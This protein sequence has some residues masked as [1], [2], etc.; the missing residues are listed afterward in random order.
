[1]L[2]ITRIVGFRYRFSSSYN[3]LKEAIADL[4]DDLDEASEEG[5]T[6]RHNSNLDQLLAKVSSNNTGEGYCN[7]PIAANVYGGIH[8][9]VDNTHPDLESDYEPMFSHQDIKDLLEFTE[10]YSNPTNPPSNSLFVHMLVSY[11]GTYAIKIKDLTKLQHLN[12]I[13]NNKDDKKDFE[14]FLDSAYRKYTDNFGNPNGTAKQYQIAFLRHI[15]LKY[16]LGIS[17]FKTKED[18]NGEPIGWEEL[19]LVDGD[20]ANPDV[21]KKPCN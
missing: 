9:H 8:L 21:E 18:T 4:K 15:N 16:D 2:K 7:Y 19:T 10:N 12:T 11:Q 3:T 5:Y 14:R 6:F 20:T 17:L 13:W 1:M